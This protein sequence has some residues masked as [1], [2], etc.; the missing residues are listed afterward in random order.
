MSNPYDRGTSTGDPKFLS[1]QY[2]ARCPDCDLNGFLKADGRRDLKKKFLIDR[3]STCGG[4]GK[5][6][7]LT[8]DLLRE[9]PDRARHLGEVGW[10]FVSRKETLDPY[11]LD[12]RPSPTVVNTP[13]R[14]QDGS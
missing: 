10:V 4:R 2:I 5:I 3:C 8:R 11:M 14:P 9:N 1:P 6:H 7:Y 12:V 13:G